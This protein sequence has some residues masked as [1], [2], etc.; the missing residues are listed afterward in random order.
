MFKIINQFNSN[1]AVQCNAMRKCKFR[2]TTLCDSCKHNCGM[3]EQ[4]NCYKKK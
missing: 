3:K 2:F 4:K 1:M